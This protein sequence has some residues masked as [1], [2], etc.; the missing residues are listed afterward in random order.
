[1]LNQANS[2]LSVNEEEFQF[3]ET[4]DALKAFGLGPCIGVAYL[5]VTSASVGLLHSSGASATS[6][7]DEFIADAV[8]MTG[9]DDEVK[10][11]VAGGDMSEGV[12]F[13]RKNRKAIVKAISDSFPDVI[14][15][16]CWNDGQCAAMFVE[17][18]TNPPGVRM[19]PI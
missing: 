17:A 18:N 15:E 13:A 1:M 3:A 16:Y 2:V 19:G 11:F 7:L 10:I 9:P 12:T 8:R 5:N 6:V 4:P 14:P